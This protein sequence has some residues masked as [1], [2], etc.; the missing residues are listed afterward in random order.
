MKKGTSPDATLTRTLWLTAITGALWALAVAVRW[1]ARTGLSFTIGLAWGIGNFLAL[2][3]LMRLK[4]ARRKPSG[5][6]VAA[7]LA[8]KILMYAAGIALLVSGRFSIGAFS[9]G[10]SWLLLAIVLRAVGELIVRRRTDA[11]AP[12]GASGRPGGDG[13]NRREE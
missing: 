6:A 8:F 7:A 12:R 10:F 9:A 2:A 1:D 5:G 3:A 4:L 11:E 13:R